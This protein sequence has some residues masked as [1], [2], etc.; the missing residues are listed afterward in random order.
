VRRRYNGGNNGDLSLSLDE[1]ARLLGIGKATAARAFAELE[2]KGFI[3]MRRGG[4]GT[5]GRRL[6][7]P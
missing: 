3:V 7:M 1:A 4:A 5:D 6:S 2:A